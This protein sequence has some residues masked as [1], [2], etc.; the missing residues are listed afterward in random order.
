[1][2]FP[3]GG[4]DIVKMLEH[5]VRLHQLKGVGPERIRT[6]VQVPD[7]VGPSPGVKIHV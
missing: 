3:H 2:D 7:E 5:V 6:A 4:E 1:V